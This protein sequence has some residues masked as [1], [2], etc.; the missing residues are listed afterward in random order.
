MA[1][2]ES[3]VSGTRL[4]IGNAPDS[5]Y[6]DIPETRSRPGWRRAFGAAKC[7]M[8]CEH[9]CVDDARLRPTNQASP[10]ATV[11]ETLRNEAKCAAKQ[12][13]PQSGP[14]PKQPVLPHTS[15]SSSTCSRLMALPAELLLAVFELAVGQYFLCGRSQCNP[16]YPLRFPS[17]WVAQ[18]VVYNPRQW[19][20]MNVFRINRAFRS[21]AIKFY[22]T[23]SRRALPFNPKVDIFLIFQDTGVGTNPYVCPAMEDPNGQSP[24]LAASG[25][26]EHDRSDDLDEESDIYDIMA[27]KRSPGMFYCNSG[28][29]T[30]PI[31]TPPIQLSSRFLARI[32][33]VGLGVLGPC[34]YDLLQWQA[35][36]TMVEILLPR[37]KVLTF[38]MWKVDCCYCKDVGF[39]DEELNQYDFYLVQDLA[40]FDAFWNDNE[41]G[42]PSLTTLKVVKLQAACSRE[43]VA[44]DDGP[45][46]WGQ[47][48]VSAPQ[49]LIP[50]ADDCEWMQD[51]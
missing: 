17:D 7:F 49:Q 41:Q 18:V 38:G 3:E 25:R 31:L 40:V 46:T 48:L 42:F 30:G 29:R 9:A 33:H 39:D 19:A 35:V 10:G 5:I 6:L 45:L 27:W 1:A 13:A 15:E 16:S 34:I 11:F 2:P 51:I 47:R 4:F 14:A 50:Y 21:M 28:D 24:Y 23:P 8:K 32:T 26:H 36:A 12:R 20:D 22:G 37:M 44:N 43:I